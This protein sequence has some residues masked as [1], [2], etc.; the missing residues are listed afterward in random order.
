MMHKTYLTNGKHYPVQQMH[1]TAYET[2]CIES[3][4][5]MKHKNQNRLIEQNR[6]E[7]QE[8]YCDLWNESSEMMF[9]F[10]CSEIFFRETIW[11]QM[12]QIVRKKQHFYSIEYSAKAFES[13]G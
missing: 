2:I 8:I 12:D 3:I 9:I 7:W 4:K 10:Y 1:F 11:K 5:I 13:I 6:N